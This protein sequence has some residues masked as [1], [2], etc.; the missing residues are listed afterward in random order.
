MPDR[1]LTRTHAAQAGPVWL[2]SCNVSTMVRRRFG[3]PGNVGARTVTNAS[4]KS[5]PLPNPSFP[6]SGRNLVNGWFERADGST[7]ELERRTSSSK[8]KTS[9]YLWSLCLH[10]QLGSRQ[11]NGPAIFKRHRAEVIFRPPKRRSEVRPDH[12]NSYKPYAAMSAAILWKVELT[13]SPVC[14]LGVPST[15]PANVFNTS[16]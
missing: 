13:T 7:A 6:K 14:T 10:F 12:C 3:P 15:T 11:K 9:V 4:P 8:L 16:G 5:P 2:I 1:S